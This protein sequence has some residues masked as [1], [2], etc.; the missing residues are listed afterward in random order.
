MSEVGVASAIVFA[1]Y[2]GILTF[3]SPC[4]YPLLPGYVGYYV[5]QTD[6][7]STLSGTV[8]R[9]VVAGA[10][11]LVT[12]GVAVGAAFVVGHSTL[13]TGLTR[14]EPLVGV[15]LVGLGI[16]IVLGF[17]PSVR[18][19]LP[20]RRSSVLGFGIFGAG[21]AVA[22]AGCVAPLFLSVLVAAGGLSAGAGAAVVGTYVGSVAVLMV[23]LTVATGMGL[24]TNASWIATHRGLLVR[25]G[26]VLVILAGLGQLYVAFYVDVQF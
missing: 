20:K 14:L 7:R 1:L 4:A 2:A 9:G 13:Q 21:Y 17:S 24:V 10:G 6:G 18:V 12:L 5:T 19:P 26:G 3:F 8:L 16:A 25:A 15:A 11:V 23:A 22:A